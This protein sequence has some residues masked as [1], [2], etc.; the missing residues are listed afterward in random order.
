MEHSQ[1]TNVIFRRPDFCIIYTLIGTNQSST[2]NVWEATQNIFRKL[3]YTLFVY[4]MYAY[5]RHRFS[6]QLSNI[7]LTLNSD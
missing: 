3:D 2:I 4:I 5:I 6:L 7:H 1:A